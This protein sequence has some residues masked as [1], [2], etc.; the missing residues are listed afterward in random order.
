MRS[1]YVLASVLAIGFFALF[2]PPAMA[3]KEYVLCEPCTFGTEGSGPGEFKEPTGIAVNESAGLEPGAGDVYVVDTGNNRIERFG[4]TGTY[5]GEFNGNGIFEVEGKVEK[6]TAAPTG[7]ILM[8][9]GIAVDDSE[10]TLLEDPSADDVYVTDV[11]HDALD[12]FSPVG[13][14]ERQLSG[15]CEKSGESAPCA[16]SKLIPF[17]ELHGVAVD[18]DG[19]VWVYEGIEEEGEPRGKLDEFSDSGAFIKA[20]STKRGVIPGIAVDSRDDAYAISG[21]GNALKFNTVAGEELA[22]F[23]YGGGTVSALALEKSTDNVLVDRANEIDLLEPFGEP[24][25]TS[26]IQTFPAQGLT[27]SNGLAIDGGAVGTPVYASERGSDDVK[28]FEDVAFPAVSSGGVSEVGEEAVTFHGVVNPT[29]EATTECRFEYGPEEAEPG[30][31]PDNVACSPHGPLSGSAP[32]EVSATATGLGARLT[33]HYRLIAADKNGS[34][35]GSDRT[36]FTVGKPIVESEVASNVSTDAATVSAQIDAAGL[37]TTYRVEYGVS[38]A[39]GASTIEISIGAPQSAVAAPAQ[40]SGL[41]P[42]TIYHYRVIA[43]NRLGSSEIGSDQTFETARSSSP[44]ASALPDD[45]ALELVSP[46]SNQDAYVPNRGP[47]DDV[48]TERPIRASADGDALVYVGEPPSTGGSGTSSKGNGDAYLATRNAAN[49]WEAT[50]IQPPGTGQEL[51]FTAFSGDLSTGIVF[52]NAV[53]RT[54]PR[55]TGNAPVNCRVLYARDDSNGVLSPVVVEPFTPEHC[56]YPAYA[57]A[58]A[59][60]QQLLFQTEAALTPNA[61]PAGAES[62][63]ECETRCNLYES[64]R[65]TLNLVS[66]VNGTAVIGTFGGPSL[67]HE[68]AFSNVISREGGYVFWTDM[69][70]GQN[71]EHVF[72]RENG[73]TTVPVSLGPAHFWTA[74]PNGRYAFYTEGEALWRFDAYTDHREAL[75]SSGDKVQGLVGVSEDGTYVYFVADEAL[76]PGASAGP[77]ERGESGGC[78]LYLLHN[79]EPVRY[80]ATLSPEDNAFAGPELALGDWMPGLNGRTAEVARDG[81]T[82]AFSSVLPLTGYN[83]QG[84]ENGEVRVPE[85][86][87]YAAAANEGKGRLYCASCDPTGA[88]PVRDLGVS[89][90]ETTRSDLEYGYKLGAFVPHGLYNATYMSRWL[91]ADGSRVFFDTAQPL[92]SQDTNGR[93]DVYEWEQEG[94]GSCRDSVGCLYLL[95]GGAT[96]DDSYLLDASESGDDVFFTSRAQF[97]PQDRNENVKVYDARVDGGSPHLSLVCTGTGCQGVPSG[98]SI[99]ATPSS[100]TFTGVGNFPQLRPAMK[101][102]LKAK[103]CKRGFVKKRGKCIKPR[104]RKASHKRRAKR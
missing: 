74:T 87:V 8:P 50:D 89:E 55:L 41:N 94:A 52:S 7:Q 38:G 44:A 76:T 92:V 104:S 90:D 59:D 46:P 65:G 1:G 42:E 78:N 60:D 75:V 81:Q 35:S 24:Y 53:E 70:A 95:S 47:A 97:V 27:E 4:V 25:G 101:V 43:T 51:R 6:S 73:T 48:F 102:R 23:E 103:Q 22:Q 93:Q 99:F 32:I 62:G 18:R 79:Q 14:Y 69:S 9:D 17:S 13:E 83:N 68:P 88:P 49:G 37:P 28:V 61:E 12:V 58:S 57:G 80:I 15:T 85:I 72:V 40:L 36:V 63:A 84:L 39:Y 98:P 66:V 71:M 67:P 19:N 96:Q 34:R 3:V 20:F 10:K 100:V 2:C 33:Y 26:V 86:Y 29:G 11:G 54:E 56:G 5:L 91:S 45:R 31:Y 82:V 30:G 77:C 64:N 21:G 16:G